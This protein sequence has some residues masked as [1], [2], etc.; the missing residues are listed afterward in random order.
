MTNAIDLSKLSDA[1]KAALLEQ[2]APASAASDPVL[3]RGKFI[4]ALDAAGSLSVGAYRQF[5][6]GNYGFTVNGRIVIDGRTFIV[7]ANMVDDSRRVSRQPNG[8]NA[9]HAAATQNG[10]VTTRRSRS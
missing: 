6:S 1:D 7:S 10:P 5:S 4:D 9:A 8:A 3:D 2:L